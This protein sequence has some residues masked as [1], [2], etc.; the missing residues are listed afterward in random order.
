VRIILQNFKGIPASG[1]ERYNYPIV[2]AK[3][4]VTT[5]EA[6][7]I[8]Q[9]H[10]VEIGIGQSGLTDVRAP[11]ISYNNTGRNQTMK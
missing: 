1:L 11:A 6:S 3:Q 8:A 4:T 9:R 2:G 5:F 7:A 10:T